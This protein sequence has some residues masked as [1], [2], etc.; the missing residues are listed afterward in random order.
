MGQCSF[1]LLQNIFWD[2]SPAHG[3]FYLCALSEESIAADLIAK[4]YQSWS[5]HTHTH[6]QL[7]L[8]SLFWRL[9]KTT[10]VEPSKWTVD[11]LCVITTRA[12]SRTFSSARWRSA[13]KSNESFLGGGRTKTKLLS[14]RKCNF[15]IHESLLNYT[16]RT[17]PVTNFTN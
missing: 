1:K 15:M 16:W 17:C 6:T 4:L 8:V 10:C 13:T 12:V 5:K 2:L 7:P 11:L 9:S 3:P 14:P